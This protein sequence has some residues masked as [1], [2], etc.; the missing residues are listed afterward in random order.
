METKTITTAFELQRLCD[1]FLESITA[2][3]S[4]PLEIRDASSLNFKETIYIISYSLEEHANFD[5][6][7]DPNT[8]KYMYYDYVAF[9]ASSDNYYFAFWN[10]SYDRVI[11]RGD[12]K[13]IEI[14]FK[15]YE[16]TNVYAEDT[17]TL[18]KREILRKLVEKLKDLFKD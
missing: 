2:R 17:D 18:M 15:G 9:G 4:D 14:R 3:K 6:I 7:H 13:V 1:E 10:N 5:Y 16:Y 11:V 8:G 12:D